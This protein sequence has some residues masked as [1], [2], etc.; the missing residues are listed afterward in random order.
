[1][2]K[3]ETSIFKL[4]LN[5]LNT[6]IFKS[7]LSYMIKGC[8]FHGRKEEVKDHLEKCGYRGLPKTISQRDFQDQV[9]VSILYR[10]MHICCVFMY[11]DIFKF[12]SFCSVCVFFPNSFCA[13][14]IHL[15]ISFKQKNIKQAIHQGQQSFI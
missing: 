10:Y 4:N 2:N 15:L 11:L 12:N 3:L 1:M 13:L 9:C 8:E 6:S 5:K 14:L 7:Y